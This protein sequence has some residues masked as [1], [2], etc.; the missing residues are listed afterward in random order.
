MANIDSIF[1]IQNILKIAGIVFSF[2]FIVLSIQ[3]YVQ[4]NSVAKTVQTG[5][6]TYII[7]ISF[8]LI[9]ISIVLMASAFF[10]L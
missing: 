1:T 10:F 3:M 2:L 8:I 9:I 5:R 6:N 4:V 7:T